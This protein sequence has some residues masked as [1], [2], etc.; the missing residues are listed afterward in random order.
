MVK[1]MANHTPVDL[2]R[3]FKKPQESGKVV[4]SNR[5]LIFTR[6]PGENDPNL[7]TVIFLK[8]VG[9]TIN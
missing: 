3:K 8:W 6:I 9:S 2:R 7:T 1:V 4:V 5:F